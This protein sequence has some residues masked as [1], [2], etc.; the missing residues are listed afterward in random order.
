MKNKKLIEWLKEL[1]E[2]YDIN[3]S[4]YTSIIDEE[5]EEEYFIV[6]DDP[7]V[8]ILKNDESKEIRLFTRT[9]KERN[10]KQIESGENWKILS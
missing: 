10:I 1:P 6:L 8:G 3:F 4:Q 5:N 7:I 9:S 2:D